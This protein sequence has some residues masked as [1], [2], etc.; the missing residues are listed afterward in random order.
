MRFPFYLF[1]TLFLV[2]IASCKKELEPDLLVLEELKTYTVFPEGSWW[3]YE[4]QNT[5]LRDSVYIYLSN[6]SESLSV[7]RNDTIIHWSIFFSGDGEGG[8]IYIYRELNH[9]KT[10]TL[11]D[12]LLVYPIDSLGQQVPFQGGAIITALDESLSVGNRLYAN[13]ITVSTEGVV[14]EHGAVPFNIKNCIFAEGVGKVYVEYH[15]GTQWI[16]KDYFI[17]N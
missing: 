6:D 4:E 3:I 9:S 16:L 10:Q 13:T 2:S 15:D 5:G 14:S 1:C 17:N 12:H 11:N 7:T 8:Y